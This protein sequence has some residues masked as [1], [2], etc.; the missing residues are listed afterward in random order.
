MSGLRAALAVLAVAFTATSLVAP[1]RA[2]ASPS[3][4]VDPAPD[5]GE[6]GVEL[7]VHLELGGGSILKWS[8][9]DETGNTFGGLILVRLRELELGLG[10]AV[11]LPDSRLQAD[12]ATFWFEG[13]Y[14]L[15]GEPR[16]LRFSPYVLAGL[17]ATLADGFEPLP[18]GFIPA[19]WS[20]EA[21]VALH[22]GAGLR[23]GVRAF[24]HTHLGLQ[25]LIGF[26]LP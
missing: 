10:A 19:R 9:F 26:A 22:L 17:G 23:W 16:P 12:F 24:N 21:N 11:A 3:P 2:E 25:L 7:H 5:T 8:A 14:H 18:T 1:A 20:R 13:R 15:L 4:A 6:D